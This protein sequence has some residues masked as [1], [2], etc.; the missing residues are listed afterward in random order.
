MTIEELKEVLIEMLNKA[1]D[2]AM[3]YDDDN[4]F[5]AGVG[6]GRHNALQDV[7]DLIESKKDQKLRCQNDNEIRYFAFVGL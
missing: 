1:E 2:E 4:S 5:S 7:M 6:V 3:L